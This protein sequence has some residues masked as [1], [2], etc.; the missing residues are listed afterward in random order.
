MDGSQVNNNAENGNISF[1]ISIILG[2]V[3][4][5]TPQNIDLT[6]K[7]LTFLGFLLGLFFAI[8]AHIY[9]VKRDKESIKKMNNE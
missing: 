7:I 3:S 1:I 9:S 5:F 6:L 2:I 4:W 8:R